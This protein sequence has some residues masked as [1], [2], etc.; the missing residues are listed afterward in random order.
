M[1]TQNSLNSAANRGVTKCESMQKVSFVRCLMDYQEEPCL[2]ILGDGRGR[3]LERLHQ[4]G[5][6]AVIL[7]GYKGDGCSLVPCPPYAAGEMIQRMATAASD[8]ALAWS[9][10]QSGAL[11][12][13][14]NDGP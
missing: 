12:T 6:V 8:T 1:Q 5:R 3:L 11:K 4:V 9:C 13:G 2:E 10:I 14:Q 7:R